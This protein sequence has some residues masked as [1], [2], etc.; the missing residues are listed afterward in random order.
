MET[1]IEILAPGQLVVLSLMF[2]TVI[3]GLGCLGQYLYKKFIERENHTS[4]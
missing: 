4:K 2:I 3:V 1:M